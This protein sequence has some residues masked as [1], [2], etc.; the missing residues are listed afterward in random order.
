MLWSVAHFKIIK[1]IKKYC[2]SAGADSAILEQLQH[3]DEQLEQF[4]QFRTQQ[5]LYMYSKA[6]LRTLC[7]AM[8]V[9]NIAEY[10]VWL[11]KHQKAETALTDREYRLQSS[12]KSM[13][14][15]LSLLGKAVPS[16]TEST[17]CSPATRAWRGTS[18]C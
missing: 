17:G 10:G 1:F 16:P 8:R 7:V 14:R 3:P 5:H 18:L 11:Q 12:Y 13:E 4:R 15:N 2:P 9:L 6:G